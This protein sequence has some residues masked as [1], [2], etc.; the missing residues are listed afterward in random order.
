MTLSK[1]DF[2][3]CLRKLPSKQHLAFSILLRYLGQELGKGNIGTARMP[4]QFEMKGW[5]EDGTD[6]WL[7]PVKRVKPTSV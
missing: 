4:A 6:D 3:I 7:L 2:Y 1:L 5:M